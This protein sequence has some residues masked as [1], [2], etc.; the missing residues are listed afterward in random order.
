[1]RAKKNHAEMVSISRKE[2][3]DM[4]HAIELQRISMDSLGKRIDFLSSEVDSIRS[5]QSRQ[6]SLVNKILDRELDAVG[7]KK[8]SVLQLMPKPNRNIKRDMEVKR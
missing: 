6:M 7:W 5:G 4:L 3:N 2:Y 8:G 1:M